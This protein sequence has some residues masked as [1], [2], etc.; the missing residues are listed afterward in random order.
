MVAAFSCVHWL[1]FAAIGSGAAWLLALAERV[2]P[3][4]FG[5]LGIFLIVVFEFGFAGAAV[6]SSA[7]MFYYLAGSSTAHRGPRTT[8]Q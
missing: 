5:L 8:A 2:P 7:V 4:G 3:L 1:V 6:F